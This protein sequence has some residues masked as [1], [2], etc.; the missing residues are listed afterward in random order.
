MRDLTARFGVVLR[1]VDA[2]A[3]GRGTP[4]AAL[5]RRSAEHRRR[6]PLWR[7]VASAIYSASSETQCI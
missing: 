4:A 1:A 5:R 3:A 2:A 7:M 6:Y